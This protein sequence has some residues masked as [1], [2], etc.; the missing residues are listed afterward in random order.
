MRDIRDGF[1]RF[2]CRLHAGT[3]APTPAREAQ[4]YV[5]HL[6]DVTLLPNHN[7][8]KDD[9]MKR[10]DSNR[11]PL[12]PTLEELVYGLCNRWKKKKRSAPNAK[13]SQPMPRPRP[14]LHDNDE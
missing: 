6:T 4:N 7:Y 2:R 12:A 11:P 5:T 13:P 3:V 8:S 9:R 14:H 10:K 1:R